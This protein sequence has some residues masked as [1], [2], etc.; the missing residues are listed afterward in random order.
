ML[1]IYNKSVPAC[2]GWK[3]EANDFWPGGTVSC[4]KLDMRRPMSLT[5]IGSSALS[6]F[7][8]ALLMSDSEL[9]YA[10]KVTARVL[11]CGL[12]SVGYSCSKL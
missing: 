11:T 10:G 5:C 6:S 7:K 12:V 9:T 1:P 3:K 4:R 2:L 8:A